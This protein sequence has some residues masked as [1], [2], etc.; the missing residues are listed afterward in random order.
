MRLGAERVESA[1]Q[2]KPLIR[3]RQIR[4]LLKQLNSDRVLTAE[5]GLTTVSYANTAC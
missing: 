5:G 2:K 1:A 4:G 3:N